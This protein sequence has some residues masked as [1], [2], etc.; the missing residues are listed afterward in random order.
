VEELTTLVARARHGDHAAYESIVRRFQDMAVGYGYAVLGDLQLAEDAAQ[1]AFLN[2]YSDLHALR[3]PAA[4]PGWF[5][6][7]VLKHVDRIRRRTRPHVP[8]DRMPEIVSRE[9]GP[10]EVVERREV[11]DR[12]YAAMEA[13]PEGQRVALTLFYIDGYSQGEISSFLEVPV[14]T[15]K[16]RLH[17]ARKRLKERMVTMVQKQLKEQRPSRDD[18]FAQKVMGLFEDMI[19][20][21]GEHAVAAGAEVYIQPYVYLSF[22][23][24]QM[25]AAG[26]TNVDF[27]QIAAVSG[28]S[29]LFGYQPGEFMP[30]YAHLYVDPDQRIADATGFGYEWVDFDGLEGAWSLLK[31]SVDAG[32]PVKGWDWENILFSNYR[33]AIKPTDRQV[34]AMADG[35]DTYAKWLTWDEFGEWVKRMG[36]WNCPRF[37]RHTRRVET[38][39]AQEVAL[40]VLKDLVAWNV[41]PPQVIQEQY[42]QAR[43][44]LA[45]IESYADDCERSDIGEDWVACHD[46][47][48]QWT[49][50]NSTGVYLKRVA[51][52]KVFSNEVNA[53]LLAAATHYCAAFECWQAFYKLLGHRA[54]E[55]ARKT[56]ARRLA[57]AA[58]AR[59]WLGHEKTALGEIEEAL[60]LMG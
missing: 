50:R 3:D 47:N 2:A 35:P 30:K 15:V 56:K 37:G 17:A 31:E 26:W 16:S 53:H 36:E 8:I 5:R 58:V 44:G 14:G 10:D 27:D 28:A 21:F 46:I 42:S 60:G 57:G 19:G 23:L 29:A 41:E 45:G 4:F 51:E 24:I 12:V 33:E 11:Q 20:R 43:F 59:A 22:H 13:L 25:H 52:A 9:P 48:P 40:R 18:A 49:I 55:V 7:I 1:E 6:R 34:F 32:L 38:K 39:P 54:S